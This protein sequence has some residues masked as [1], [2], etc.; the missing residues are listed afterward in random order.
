MRIR[1]LLALA[2]IG[3]VASACTANPVF[4]DHDEELVAEVTF[5]AEHLATL[6]EFTITVHVEDD[7]GEHVTAMA[8]VRAE[9][10]FHDTETW[11]A[12]TL[13]LEGEEF[14]GT[15]MFMSSGEYDF[16]VIGIQLGQ[17]EEFVLYEAAEHMEV[18]RIH[19]EVGDFI[20]EF[21][22][23]P[24]HVHEGGEAAARFWI[25]E[26]EADPDGHHHMM[27]GLH[28]EIHVTDANGAAMEHEAHEE[29]AGIYEAHHTFLEAGEARFEIHFEGMDGA[30]HHAEFHVPVSHEH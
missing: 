13:T 23:F 16:R 22:T 27:A 9:F 30:E 20:V 8:E 29:E 17:V 21:E 4:P 6:T 26:A 15:H 3:P 2:L 11:R 18:E 28:A 25:M 5:S 14:T 12:E 24:G 19:V 1:R 7:H 10:R